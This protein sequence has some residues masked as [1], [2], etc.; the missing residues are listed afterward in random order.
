M[1]YLEE[2]GYT[3]DS[4]IDDGVINFDK[5]RALNNIIKNREVT[6]FLDGFEEGK[7]KSVEVIYDDDYIIFKKTLYS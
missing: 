2:S 6:E 5:H 1:D 7:Y 4:A 3:I